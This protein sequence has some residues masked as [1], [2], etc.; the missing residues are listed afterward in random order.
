MVLLPLLIVA[1]LAGR[2]L[3]IDTTLKPTDITG[4][5][6]A[7]AIWLPPLRRIGEARLVIVTLAVAGMIVIAGL[8]P[9]TFDATPRAFGW[10]PFASFL[11]GSIRVAIQA[12]CEKFFKYASLI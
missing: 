1:E 2:V 11:R 6:L 4:A 8:Q 3:I 9:F 7:V 5:G 12:F 10:V